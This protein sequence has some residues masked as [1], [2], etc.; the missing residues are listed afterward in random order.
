MGVWV[1]LCHLLLGLQNESQHH[2]IRSFIFFLKWHLTHHD[3]D[4]LGAR[5]PH[6]VSYAFIFLKWSNMREERTEKKTHLNFV[7]G[8]ELTI[9][10]DTHNS[11]KLTK[12]KRKRAGAHLPSVLLSWKSFSFNTQKLLSN[13]ETFSVEL[14]SWSNQDSR[15]WRDNSAS[16]MLLWNPKLGSGSHLPKTNQ[17]RIFTQS[18]CWCNS[19]PIPNGG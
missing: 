6:S 19:S 18:T 9:Q 12:R 3:V 14:N 17:W 15:R 5:Q 7:S 1:T 16:M 10:I 11:T 2:L 13:W 4:S 8:R